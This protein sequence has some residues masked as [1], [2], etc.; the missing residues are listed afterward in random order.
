MK[1]KYEEVAGFIRTSFN[2]NI[3][4]PSFN[5]LSSCFKMHTLIQINDQR[6]RSYK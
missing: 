2:N 1:T 4:V 3:S 5:D 6:V